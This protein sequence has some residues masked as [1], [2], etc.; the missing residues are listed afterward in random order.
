MEYIHF[1][2]KIN[3]KKQTSLVIGG[4]KILNFYKH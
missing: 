3:H 4:L 2:V 1:D